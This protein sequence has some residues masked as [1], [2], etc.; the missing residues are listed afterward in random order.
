M[1]LGLSRN[2]SSSICNVS[3][4]CENESSV[5]NIVM[6]TSTVT[7][8]LMYLGSMVYKK[9]A[10]F[11][12]E[13]RVRHIVEKN[14]DLAINI[15]SERLLEAPLKAIQQLDSLIYPQILEIVTI[16]LQNSLSNGSMT[17]LQKEICVKI[18]EFSPLIYPL[19]VE[20]TPDFLAAS[21][22]KKILNILDGLVEDLKNS[23]QIKSTL[24]ELLMPPVM[25]LMPLLNAVKELKEASQTS[26]LNDLIDKSAIESSL[27]RDCPKTT[28]ALQEIFTLYSLGESYL[29]TPGFQEKVESSLY[30][31]VLIGLDFFSIPIK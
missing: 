13:K 29:R 17:Q 30:S 14:L 12:E 20:N 9:A 25:K 23:E 24:V 15:V 18:I 6:V 5:L 22:M 10:R 31:M 16:N 8:V 4:E 11:I 19:L 21:P 3:F 27:K 7:L 26:E 2:V 1:D 28:T